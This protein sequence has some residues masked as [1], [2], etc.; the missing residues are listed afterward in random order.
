[1][2][3]RVNIVVDAFKTTVENVNIFAVI[4]VILIFILIGFF[5][6]FW[7]K[8]EEF[9]SKRYLK[10]LFYRNGENYG[11]TKR[12]LDILWEYSYRLNK[13]PFLVLEYKSPFEKVVHAYVQ[14]NPQ[15]N[16]NL[17][18]SMRKT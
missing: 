5:L 10:K 16:E 13:D 7:E 11:L 4:I 6:V 2:D 15:Y 18:K 17:I 9:L 3:E 1:M 14:N 8:F 12:E